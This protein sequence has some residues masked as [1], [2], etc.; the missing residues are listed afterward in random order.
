M[1]KLRR[2]LS[3]AAGQGLVEFSL[4]LPMMLVVALGVIEVSYVLLDQ[5]VVTKLAREGSNLISR[6]TSIQDAVTALKSMSTRPVD[7]TTDAKMIFSVVTKVAT[8]GATNFDKEVL[9]QRHE[10]GNLAG[11]SSTLKTVGNG[12]FRGAP[13]YE[14]V[15]VDNDANLQITNLPANLTVPQGGRIYVTEVYTKHPLITPFDQ[16]GITVPNMLYSIA[17]F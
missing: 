4:T 2:R 1:T 7:F 9:Y 13:D 12:A 17:Y 11:V 6:D 14:A 5:H 16:W 15:N 10:Y 8:V 3:D